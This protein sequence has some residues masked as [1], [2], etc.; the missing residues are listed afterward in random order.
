M[1]K[2]YEGKAN[3]IFCKIVNHNINSRQLRDKL[4]VDYNILIKDCSNKTSLNDK[5]VR[6]AVRKPE[7]NKVLV[8]A[9]IEI[10]KRIGD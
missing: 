9:L 4:F 5:F 10:E 6:I 1:L 8:N 3:F 2:P 7:E